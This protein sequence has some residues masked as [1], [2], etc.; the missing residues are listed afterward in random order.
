MKIVID[1]EFF[2]DL[3]QIRVCTFHKQIDSFLCQHH[4]Q[5]VG[6]DAVFIGKFPIVLLLTLI[7]V[8]AIV[9]FVVALIYISPLPLFIPGIYLFLVGSV[10]RKIFK[11]YLPLDTTEDT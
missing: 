8:I 5:Q 2:L 9:G 10:F 7:C 1:S 11:E 4:L 6:L 3:V